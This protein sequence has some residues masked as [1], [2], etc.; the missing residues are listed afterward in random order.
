M[1]FRP[2]SERIIHN[3]GRGTPYIYFAFS[4]ILVGT[5]R[6]AVQRYE[7]IYFLDRS[8]C[9]VS[10]FSKIWRGLGDSG[11]KGLKVQLQTQGATRV[12]HWCVL[13]SACRRAVAEQNRR[14]AGKQRLNA[15]RNAILYFFLVI[16]IRHATTMRPTPKSS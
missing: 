5:G 16:S 12:H 14:C 1:I 7:H 3:R 13:E 11:V 8:R 4:P 6:G 15:S 2:Q 9:P 10:D